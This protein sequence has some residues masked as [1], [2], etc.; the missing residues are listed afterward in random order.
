MIN[1]NPTPTPSLNP[2]DINM[3]NRM[4]ADISGAGQLN[5]PTPMSARGPVGLTRDGIAAEE[6]TGDEKPKQQ[7]KNKLTEQK[8]DGQKH[9]EGMAEK[10]SKVNLEI[11]R[12]K[13]EL[14][15]L[16]SVSRGITFNLFS[17]QEQHEE[18]LA[19]INKSMA[20]TDYS[21]SEQIAALQK[22]IGAEVKRYDEAAE[23]M[24]EARDSVD[25]RAKMTEFKLEGMEIRASIIKAL[26]AFNPKDSA[27]EILG[28]VAKL[29]A[30]VTDVQG[31][32]QGVKEIP[33]LHRFYQDRVEQLESYLKGFPPEFDAGWG[34][35]WT[36]ASHAQLD[37]RVA[38]RE[39]QQM[40]QGLS[41]KEAVLDRVP[42]ALANL[43]TQLADAKADLEF[44]KAEFAKVMASNP[45]LDMSEDGKSVVFNFQKDN[46]L[47]AANGGGNRSSG[48]SCDGG[49][50]VVKTD[51]GAAGG[52]KSGSL[53]DS[54]QTGGG[55]SQTVT[56]TGDA[57]KSNDYGMTDQ[58]YERERNALDRKFLEFSLKY[59]G[60]E[61]A[62]KQIKGDYEKVK[63]ELEKAHDLYKIDQEMAK[64]S[65]DAGHS[66]TRELIRADGS[67]DRAI[68]A[69]TD[70]E[71]NTIIDTYSGNEITQDKDGTVV[72]I[73]T[74]DGMT[75][76][77]G[78]KSGKFIVENNKTH[79]KQE[80]DTLRWDDEF[81][82]VTYFDADGNR[83][84]HSGNGRTS[85][86]AIDIR[87]GDDAFRQ[88]VKTAYEDS[89]PQSAKDKVATR[90]GGLIVAETLGDLGYS[91]RLNTSNDQDHRE[92]SEVPGVTEG[93]VAKVAQKIKSAGETDWHNVDYRPTGETTTHEFGHA[94]EGVLYMGERGNF[95]EVYEKERNDF[96]A[97][98]P[99]D[100]KE[101]L[102]YFV[103]PGKGAA[104]TQAELWAIYHNN[105]NSVETCKLLKEH[106]PETFKEIVRMET[107]ELVDSNPFR[108]SNAG[109]NAGTQ[110]NRSTGANPDSPAP[111]SVKS[112]FTYDHPPESA[113][114]WEKFSAAEKNGDFVTMAKTA[115]AVANANGSS[116]QEADANTRAL[117][118]RALDH[119]IHTIE[120]SNNPSDVKAAQGLLRELA[121]AWENKPAYTDQKKTA[122]SWKNYTP[123]KTTTTTVD[124][125]PA[126]DTSSGGGTVSKSGGGSSVKPA[127]LSKSADASPSVDA[128]TSANANSG[129]KKNEQS[130]ADKVI[131]KGKD[132]KLLIETEKE[133][134]DRGL[135]VQDFKD[136]FK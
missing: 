134:N 93:G 111:V 2:T 110:G 8:T 38:A 22:A 136:M 85:K 56:P 54:P 61:G 3:V 66:H 114:A 1:P 20:I 13:M 117:E 55:G 12:L 108:N 115:A 92:W 5:G 68:D 37:Y 90:E 57:G 19:Q 34:L 69:H 126:K 16:K 35:E 103:E 124:P 127:D 79:E 64:W 24:R 31:S 63:A 46:N 26:S 130:L 44:G 18:R 116:S 45:R 36:E 112:V 77:P 122:D 87:S 67:G 86:R 100:L 96:L 65:E 42:R 80:V 135:S 84:E 101:K 75:I 133:L 6:M 89:L 43:S 25:V 47:V 4:P 62:L 50:T 72:K 106:F 95:N 53:P 113:T 15:S 73:A 104:E 76:T 39:L 32:I 131:N 11:T 102:H 10:L 33:V 128:K 119:A 88:R 99:A 94:F 125:G 71:G 51:G 83:Y 70:A 40:H 59:K 120:N 97:K 60:D 105:N 29:E 30:R 52:G 107:K 28:E 81:G 7:D 129:S 109:S 9:Q 82:I 78:E 132:A 23:A 17:L 21:D 41:E 58:R 14:D 74:K 48:G 123:P 49:H 91:G 98:A 27:N 121:N 118:S